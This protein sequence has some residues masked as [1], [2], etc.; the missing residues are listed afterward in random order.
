MVERAVGLFATVP[1]TLVHALNFFIAPAGSLVL[2]R[3]WNW[4]KRVDGGERVSSLHALLAETQI[5]TR[6]KINNN[7]ARVAGVAH[8]MRRVCRL[9]KTYCGWSLYGRYHGRCGRAGRRRVAIMHAGLGVLSS[10]FRTR[11]IYGRLRMTWIVLHIV[12][13]CVW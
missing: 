12:V 6:A 11:R 1:A 7:V 9:V 10:P 13:R 2:L 5:K 3:T 8:K 4:D